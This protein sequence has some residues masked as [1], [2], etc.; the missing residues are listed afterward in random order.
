MDG[1]SVRDAAWFDALFE[2]HTEEVVAMLSRR[3]SPDQ[4]DAAL[5]LAQKTFATA[6]LKRHNVPDDPR[7]WLFETAKN[8]LRNHVRWSQ[9]RQRD[10][11]GE[12]ALEN[13][14]SSSVPGSFTL[15]QSVDLRRALAR[16]KKRDRAIL[17]MAYVE[18]LT[19]EEIADLE[20][21]SAEAVRQ[22]LF[23]ARDEIRKALG[24]DYRRNDH[25][26]RPREAR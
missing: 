1:V 21:L 20:G 2:K 7:P 13:A 15:E 14:L 6:W 11:G 26:D 22:R 16:I 12:E 5:D 18:R 8:H 24:A 19:S 3:L 10:L 23:R 17:F 4:A 9:R 25:G